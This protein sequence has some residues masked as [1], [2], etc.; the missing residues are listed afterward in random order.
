MEK[1]RH[2]LQTIGQIAA[3]K[4]ELEALQPRAL[5]RARALRGV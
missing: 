4:A 3:G 2:E 5:V 1:I